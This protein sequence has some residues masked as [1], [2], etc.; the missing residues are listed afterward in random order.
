MRVAAI[1][2]EYNPFHSGHAYHI[3]KTRDMGFTHIAAVMSGS[4]VQRG[5]VAVADQHQR[6]AAAVR[7][8]ADLVLELAPPYS[9]ASARDFAM[10]AVSV[11]DSLGCISALSFGSE[12]CDIVRLCGCLDKI[13]AISSQSLKPLI[14][15]GLTYP[16]AIARLVPEYGG[17]L[18]EPNSVLAL[19]YLFALR[20]TGIEPVAIKRTVPHDG[21][22][23]SDFASAM[24]IRRLL[25]EGRLDE[26]GK[27]LSETPDPSGLYFLENGEDAILYRLYFA[28]KKELLR[29]P[30][31]NEGMAARLI[32]SLKDSAGIYEL[33]DRAKSRN[34]THARLRRA[35]LM[36]AVGATREDIY[37]PVEDGSAGLLPPP[38][39]RVLAANSRGLELLAAA[40]KSSKMP[41]GHS[42]ARLSRTSPRAKRI[43]DLTETCARL[44]YHC[45]CDRKM[46][47]V[48]EYE[49]NAVIIK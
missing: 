22:S 36:Y 19:E 14:S 25:R 1:V 12:E 49:K 6:A 26:C 8:G 16:Q 29:V 40:K 35:V 47:F 46:P 5:D 17:L 28:D 34:I 44:R 37:S 15:S 45:R 20:G 10:G 33:F 11:I 27:Y 23:P 7:G 31:M 42:L 48:S 3:K 38:F 24:A 18:S 32:G 30:G 4:L 39:A 9:L 21:G 13:T 41:L 43:A 2:A